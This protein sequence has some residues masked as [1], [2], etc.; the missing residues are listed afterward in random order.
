VNSRAV[1]DYIQLVEIMGMVVKNVYLV[2]IRL[3]ISVFRADGNRIVAPIV[4]RPA[5]ITKFI[6]DISVLKLF[7]N[8]LALLYNYYTAKK[9]YNQDKN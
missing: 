2:V 8:F 9:L 4:H 7:Y 6:H 3:D 1:G 5:F